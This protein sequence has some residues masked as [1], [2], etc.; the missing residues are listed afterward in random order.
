MASSVKGGRA[1]PVGTGVGDGVAVGTGV[2]RLSVGFAVGTKAGCPVGTKVGCPVGT[3]IPP[4]GAC[5]VNRRCCKACV[6]VRERRM[7]REG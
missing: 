3:G 7:G 5:V 4:V 2:V 6:H 1:R